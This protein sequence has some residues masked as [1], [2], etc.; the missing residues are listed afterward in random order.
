MIRV[1]CCLDREPK[2]ALSATGVVVAGVP[3]GVLAAL[4]LHDL[5][6]CHHVCAFLY[7]AN[8]GVCSFLRTGVRSLSPA[9]VRSGVIEDGFV[10]VTFLL[11]GAGGKGRG[12]EKARSFIS[13]ADPPSLA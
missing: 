8:S 13:P 5:S 9:E 1:H 11:R 4:A 12:A 10:P 3:A 7:F 2:G 6:N